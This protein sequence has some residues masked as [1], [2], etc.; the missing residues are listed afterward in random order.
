MNVDWNL[1]ANIAVPVGTLF[2]GIW[3]DRRFELRPRLVTYY[4]HVAAFSV[5]QP[6][7]QP[8]LTVHTHSVVLRNT[9]RRSATDVRIR[10][11]PLQRFPHF[12]I[13]P[14]LQHHVEDL[15]GGGGREIVIPILVPNEEITISYLYFPPT[16]VVQV[17]AGIRSAEGFARGIPVLLQRQFPRWVNRV[18]WI[19]LMIGVMTII[20]FALHGLIWLVQRAWLIGR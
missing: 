11:Q 3:L 20:Y 16:T 2:L 1:L 13:W 18:S 12:V 15:P 8:P 9:G 17:H 10:H 4:G 19:V 14:Q 7:G 6:A 5:D